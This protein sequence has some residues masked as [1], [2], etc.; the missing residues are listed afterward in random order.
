MLPVVSQQRFNSTTLIGLALGAYSTGAIAGALLMSRWKP[1][2]VG[3]PAMI[4]LGAYGL[5]PVSL[6]YAS[7][8]WIIIA[9][10]AVGGMGIEVFNIP[11][12]TAI[13]REVPGRLQAR[14][15]SLDFLISYGMSPVGFALIPIMVHA[16]GARAVL[17]FAG[18]AVIGSAMVTLLVPGMTELRD[19]RNREEK[20][21][22]ISIAG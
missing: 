21:E 2:H 10:C 7:H 3:I 5:V 14:I 22:S 16:V 15:F 1:R 12:F 18:I 6:A 20:H 19:P 4:M 17:T 11:W 9:A 13:Q 8:I